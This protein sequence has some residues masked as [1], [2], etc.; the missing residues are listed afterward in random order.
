MFGFVQTFWS[1]VLWLRSATHKK[2]PKIESVQLY[3][4]CIKYFVPYSIRAKLS[5]IFGLG[6]VLTLCFKVWLPPLSF[7]A[8]PFCPDSVN[9]QREH[10][11]IAQCRPPLLP[12]PMPIAW[13]I[14]LQ[15]PRTVH[16]FYPDKLSCNFSSHFWYFLES[17]DRSLAAVSFTQT[18]LS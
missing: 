7:N 2:C 3:C 16:E 11:A 13:L 8:R 5:K 4:I 17:S 10:K 12:S 18:T 14:N 1:R 6:H 15:T 9:C